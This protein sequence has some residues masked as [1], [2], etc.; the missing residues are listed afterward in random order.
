MALVTHELRTPLTAIQGMSEVLEQYQLNPEEQHEMFRAINDEA[1]RLARMIEEYLDISRIESGARQ[2]RGAPVRVEKLL[3]EALLKLRPVAAQRRLSII[4]R[5]APDLPVIMAD[6]DLLTRAVTNLISN[7]I[8]YSPAGKEITINARAEGQALRIEVVD[9]GYGIP[10]ADLER[11][12][13]KFYRVSRAEDTDVQ[14]TG[15]GLAF[16]R[17]IVELHGGR[18]TV[19]SVAGSGSTFSLLLPLLNPGAAME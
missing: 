8:K 3:E 6:S 10:A 4:R 13:E 9:Q 15:L 14:G 16:V 12:F 2:L 5:V 18:V 7:A 11:I 19:S 17:E 1:K